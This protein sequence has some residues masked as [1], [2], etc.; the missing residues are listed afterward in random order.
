MNVSGGLPNLGKTYHGGTPTSI[1]LSIDL[2]GAECMFRDEVRV[3]SQPR[4]IRSGRYRTA[5]L[6][7][8]VSGFALEPGR[9][10]SWAPGF[11]GTRVAGYA[12]L[13]GQE[14]AGVTDSF[15]PATG[16]ANNDLFW[17]LRKGPA[18]VRTP[19]AGNATNV[20]GEG[21]VVGALTAITSGAATAGRLGQVASASTVLAHSVM[22][23]RIGR[24]ISAATTAMTNA[25][26]LI[27][28]EILS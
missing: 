13:D 8:N 10:V 7:R 1:G 20:F 11:R 22:A 25:E 14:V 3:R 27:D 18:L 2:E 5:R 21:D 26:I 19:L 4:Q 24:A 17:V 6:V 9:L 28:L 16:V 15:L 12:R 23:N